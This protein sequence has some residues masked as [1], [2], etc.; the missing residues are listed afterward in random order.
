VN[1]L[2]YHKSSTHETRSFCLVSHGSVHR[3]DCSQCRYGPYYN[4]PGLLH[5]VERPTENPL[6]VAFLPCSSS[7]HLLGDYYERVPSRMMYVHEEV[8]TMTT[9]LSHTQTL[10]RH[11]C[12]TLRFPHR[13]TPNAH[14]LSPSR[15]VDENMS[16]I[17]VKV[18]CG[19]PQKARICSFLGNF[20]S[21]SA[22]WYFPGNQQLL[23]CAED[24]NPPRRTSNTNKAPQQTA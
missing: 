19:V 4:S 2:W 20:G 8:T 15:Q 9:A 22:C 10:S 5:T 21:S 12:Y 18:R 16:R 7:I 17:V 23:S 6:S 3:E 1:N 24:A 13:S 11:G 14:Y